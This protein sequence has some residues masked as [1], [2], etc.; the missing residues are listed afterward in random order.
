MRQARFAGEGAPPVGPI[1]VDLHDGER[2]ALS[3]ATNR[4]AS[5]AA[6]LAAAIVK[7]TGGSVLVD[8]FDSRIQPAACKRVVGYVPRDPLPLDRERFRDLVSYRAQL[9]GIDPQRA[10]SFSKRLLERLAGVHEAFAYPIVAALVTSPHVLIVDRA[11]PSS[12]AAIL[13]AA[14]GCAILS[15]RVYG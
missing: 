12:E 7:P 9:W 2:V 1:E 4:E 8:S 15:M 3:F 10:L 13:A 11:Q 14:D 6:M 5:V